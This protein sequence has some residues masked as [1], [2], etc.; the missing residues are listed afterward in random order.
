MTKYMRMVIHTPN[1]A[2]YGQKHEYCD[3]GYKEWD[4]MLSGI[5][6]SDYLKIQTDD[7]GSK[8]FFPGTF[9]KNC[10]AFIEVSEA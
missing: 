6:S 1:S 2:Y 3:K 7:N 10:V 4:N 9:L 8:M 5:D